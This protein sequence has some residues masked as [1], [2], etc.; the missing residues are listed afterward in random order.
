MHLL[1]EL[2]MSKNENDCKT[3]EAKDYKTH[4]NTAYAKNTTQKLG[5]YEERSTN[6]FNKENKVG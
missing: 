5:W 1:I 3:S 2:K 6:K 4:S